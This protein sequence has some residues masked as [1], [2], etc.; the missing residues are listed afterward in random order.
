MI[1]RFIKFDVVKYSRQSFLS[2]TGH[3]CNR[4]IFISIFEYIKL[5]TSNK[6]IGLIYVLQYLMMKL[7]INYI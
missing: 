4:E 3:R 5:Y 6:V 7:I 2:C 1:N